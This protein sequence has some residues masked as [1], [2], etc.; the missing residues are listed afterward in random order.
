METLTKR[1]VGQTPAKLWEVAER[2]AR[3]GEAA[4]VLSKGVPTYRVEFLGSTPDPLKELE[5]QGIYTPPSPNP[6]PA[7]KLDISYTLEDI[8]VIMAGLRAE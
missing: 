3:N 5:H 2:C 8:D 6:R 4:Y 7:P 1:D